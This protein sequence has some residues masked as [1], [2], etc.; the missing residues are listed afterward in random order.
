M[1]SKSAENLAQH[2]EPFS[3]QIQSE[4]GRTTDLRSTHNQQEIWA[5]FELGAPFLEPRVEQRDSFPA[6][7][8]DR[9]S[10][11]RLS[12]IAPLAAKRQII[13]AMLART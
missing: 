11:I 3:V 13:E 10:S 9:V 4:H 5:P 1:L 2:N 8:I 12:A 6:H 7:G